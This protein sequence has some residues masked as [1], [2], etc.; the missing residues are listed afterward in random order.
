MRYCCALS[1]FQIPN[2]CDIVLRMIAT[3]IVNIIA[4]IELLIGLITIIGLFISQAAA[5]PQ[6]PLNV[7]IFVLVAAATSSAIGIGIFKRWRWAWLLLVFFSGYIVITKIMLL[8]GLL[9]FTG[10]I[11]AVIP[12]EMK[13]YISIA[14]HSFI[15]LYFTRK[16]IRNDFQVQ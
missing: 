2:R 3:I 7:F 8:T 5:F 13:N 1:V 10:E 14:Y 6:K 15:V 12:M 16:R 11:I 9:I 4:L